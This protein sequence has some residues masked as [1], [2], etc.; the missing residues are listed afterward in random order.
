MTYLVYNRDTSKVLKAYKTHA[1]AQAALTRAF[2]KT[3]LTPAKIG[4]TYLKTQED[5]MRLGIAEQSHFY[6]SIDRVVIVRSL[7]TGA[8]VQIRESD[9]G[10]PCDPSTERY[11]SM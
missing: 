4:R 10:G 7:M 9:R 5:V 11:W 2:K 3:L 8:E 1:A 6:N